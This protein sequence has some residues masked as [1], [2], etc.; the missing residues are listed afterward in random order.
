MHTETKLAAAPLVSIVLCTYNGEKFLQPQL[1]SLENQ[2]YQNIEVICSDNNSSDSTPVL[3]K[4]WCTKN[5]NRFFVSCTDK[6][7]NKNFFSAIK[8]A[9]G[10]YI[11]FCDQDD[12]W[13]ENKVEELIN[14]HKINKE[15]SM[16][17]CRSKA[18][19]DTVPTDFYFNF[20]QHPL[21]GNQIKKTLLSSFTLG[22]N[23]CIKKEIL[24]QIPVPG[25]EV[26][27]FDWWITVSAMCLS[28]I[29]CL[30]KVRTLWRHH[31]SNTTIDLRK[32]LV[33]KSRIGYLK[34]FL[35]NPLINTEDKKWIAIAIQ[36]H[37]ELDRKDF[38]FSLFWFLLKN[39]SVIY[40]YKTKKNPL[41]KWISFTKWAMR[42]SRRNYSVE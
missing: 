10:Q 14:F 3:L 7:L 24:N 34:Q 35:T 32:G 16:V 30:P 41:L 20:R 39:A 40:F 22:H 26:I 33:Y 1:D 42:Q 37:E 36:K 8:Y 28:E 29:K 13:H 4:D 18:F 2:T 23:I 5:N 21:E 31:T 6:G 25:N 19:A 27:A 11:L 38:S 12:I 17:Y 15:A 9:N